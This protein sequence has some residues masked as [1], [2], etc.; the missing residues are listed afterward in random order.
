VSHTL[1][2]AH[3]PPVSVGEEHG[4]ITDKE[5]NI[6]YAR[7]IRSVGKGRIGTSSG[8]QRQKR[9]KYRFRWTAAEDS[10]IAQQGGMFTKTEVRTIRL[11]RLHDAS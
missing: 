5:G 11:E 6:L 9:E 2:C 8:V 7:P 3:L 10:K 4:S 1:S